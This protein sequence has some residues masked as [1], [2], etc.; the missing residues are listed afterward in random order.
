MSQTLNQLITQFQTIASNHKQ[1]NTFGFGDIWEIATSGDITYPM[2]WVQLEDSEISGKV[3]TMNFSFIFCDQVI[4][5]EVN[6]NEVLSDQLEVA[7]D[8]IAQLN[9]PDYVWKFEADGVTLQDFTERFTDSVAGWTA[10]ISLEI[11]FSFDRCKMPY[12]GNTS[13][14]SACPVVTIFNSDGSVNTTV[15]AGGS[16]TLSA[17]A[18]VSGTYNIYVNGVLNQSGTSTDLTNET[19]NISA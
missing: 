10:K 5:G 4:N 18:T 19:F 11:P 15:N 6:E 2:M 7:K 8:V 12:E 3:Q 9:H 16:Y 17:G 13:T 1:I 14:S